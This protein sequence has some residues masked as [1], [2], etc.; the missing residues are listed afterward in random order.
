MVSGLVLRHLRKAVLAIGA[1]AALSASALA[2]MPGP[3]Q[4]ATSGPCDIYASGGTPCAAAYSMDRAL[5]AA[6]DGPLYQ[7]QRASDGTTK[8]I[9]LLAAGGYVDATAQDSFC[10]D[11]GC[12]VTK[13]YDQ[14][15]EWNDLTIAGP[16][17]PTCSSAPG[18]SCSGEADHGADASMVPVTVGGSAD[19]EAYGLDITGGVGYA[20]DAT[21]GVATGGQPEG[22][23]MVASGTNVNGQ[24][25]MDFG[26]AETSRDDDGNGH[27]DAVYFGKLCSSRLQER[28][29]FARIP[30]GSRRRLEDCP[31]AGAGRCDRQGHAG[32]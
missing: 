5:Y 29:L 14:S 13:I 7:V 30:D 15:P 25:C 24:C 3:A 12:T 23:Y 22:T 4:A 2:A 27:M 8:D 26:N 6:Y 31:R 32:D 16:G 10:F 28:H 21:N 19:I 1:A 9:G 17:G 20:D 18:Y 11:T